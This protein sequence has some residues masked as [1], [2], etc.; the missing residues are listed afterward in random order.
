MTDPGQFIR[1]ATPADIPVW[2]ELSKARYPDRDVAAGAKWVEWCIRHPE[3]LVLVGKTHA[4]I[5]TVSWHYGIEKRASLVLMFSASGAPYGL[6]GVAMLRAMVAWAKEM[7]AIPP[8]RVGSDNGTD[9]GAFAKRLG[10]EMV[11][12][13]HYAIP[14]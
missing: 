3:R 8:F 13:P 11:M 6:E 10:G 4:G 7:G 2:V 9:L 14:F 1:R 12:E 5:A